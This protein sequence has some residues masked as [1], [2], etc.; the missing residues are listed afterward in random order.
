MLQL[1]ATKPSI[2]IEKPDRETA[3]RI[4]QLQTITAAYKTISSTDPLLPSADSPLPALLA[5]RSTL[6]LV[7]ETKIAIRECRRQIADAHSRLRC[8]DA[9]LQDARRMTV[10]LEER[11]GNLRLE[12]GEMERNGP[13]GTVAK[14]LQSRQ[15]KISAYAKELKQLVLAFNKFIDEHLAVMIAAE[16]LGGPVAGEDLS[17]NEA[18]LKAGFDKQ[19]KVRNTKKGQKKAANGEMDLDDRDLDGTAPGTERKAAGAGMRRLTEELLNAL[20]D[21]ENSES[22]ITISKESAAVRFLIRAKIAQFHPNDSRKL[23][24]MDFTAKSLGTS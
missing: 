5:L 12:K 24:L 8:E 9:D 14:I 15:Q 18:M 11:A 20:A 21:E 4:R 13:E 3:S 2:S 16:Q 7:D 23:R 22:Y 10:A 1:R 17:I 19:G 6:K